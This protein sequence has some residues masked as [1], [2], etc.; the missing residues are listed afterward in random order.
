[1]NSNLNNL[2]KLKIRYK[3]SGILLLLIIIFPIL[4]N[5]NR[6]PLFIGD[7]ANIDEGENI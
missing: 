2:K 5:I 6:I 7:I 4:L 3:K 1:M